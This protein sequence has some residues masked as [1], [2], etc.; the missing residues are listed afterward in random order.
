MGERN[1][2]G[3]YTYRA[4]EVHRPETVGEVQS[5]VAAA[6]TIRPLGSR[7]SFN[8][9]A[10]TQHAQLSL[11]RIAD[12]IEIDSERMTAR[13]SAGTRYGT[14]AEYLNAR[15]YALHNMA[16]LPH[17]SVAGAIATATH[18][19]GD[20]N[21]CLATGV[22]AMEFVTATGDIVEVSGESTPDF[23]GMVVGLG[24]L[25]V[26]TSVTLSLSENFLVRQQVFEDLPWQTLLDHYDEI[27]RAAYSVSVF[28]DWRGDT[29]R[30]VWVKEQVDQ[31]AE[32]GRDEFFGARAASVP[33][34]MLPEVSAENTTAQ[35]GIAGAWHDRLPHFRLG[36]R[37]S[38]GAELQ[39]EYLVPREHAVGAFSAV[40][41]LAN[42][43]SPLLQIAELRTI[44]ADELWLSMAYRR[45]SAALHFTWRPRQ[46]EVEAILPSIEAALEPFGARPHWGKVFMTNPDAVGHLY[47]RL[48]DFR[49]LAES[50]D[51]NGKFRNIFLDRYI[52]GR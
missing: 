49:A 50:M 22:V 15:G 3:N 46:D 26:V 34:H 10:D 19:S 9:L 51:P 14:I 2:A 17:I 25:G 35:L 5:I 4:S 20:S 21:G 11:E 6:D 27:T 40:K 8:S 13:V 33:R 7:H 16:S 36:F 43:V 37:P 39:T 29:A 32:C 31:A 52:F 45:S 44:A 1:W 48:D 18:G 47:P 28:T 24:A 41:Q 38:S 12:T 42:R 23:D 30:Q